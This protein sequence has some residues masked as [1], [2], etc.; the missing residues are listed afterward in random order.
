MREHQLGEIPQHVAFGPVLA[1]RP[2]AAISQ[3]RQPWSR[4][5][6]K[7]IGAV[8][9]VLLGFAAN[10][11]ATVPIQP[12]SVPEPTMLLMMASGVGGAL[13]Y[14]RNRRLRK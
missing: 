3:S 2:A 11:L 13:L 14:A 4:Q 12:P 8:L 5:M 9:V 1:R 6:P 7:T 10:A